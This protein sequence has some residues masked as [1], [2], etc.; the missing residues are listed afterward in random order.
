MRDE[1][2]NTGNWKEFRTHTLHFKETDLLERDHDLFKVI[3]FNTEMGSHPFQY[4]PLSTQ[5][6]YKS[7]CASI[8]CQGIH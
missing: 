5:R 3:K 1:S 2:Q 4:G 6:G 7:L 8:L